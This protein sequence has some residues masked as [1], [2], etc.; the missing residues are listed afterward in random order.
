MNDTMG[1][2]DWVG[3]P[4]FCSHCG[5]MVRSPWVGVVQQQPQD[6]GQ[7]RD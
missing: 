6:P 2:Q 1:P 4:S 5:T 7:G 3:S